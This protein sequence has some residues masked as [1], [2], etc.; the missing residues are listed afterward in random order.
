LNDKATVTKGVCLITGVGPGTGTALVEA[1]V[2]GGYAVAMLARTEE[3]LEALSSKFEHAHAF[4]CDVLDTAKLTAT[5]A[6]IRTTLGAP[7]IVIHN[8]VGGAFGDFMEIDPETLD[9]NFQI[10]T[11]ALLHLSRLVADDMIEAGQG[12]ILATGNTSA[13]RGKAGFAG[14]APSKAAQRILLESIARAVGPKGIHAVYVAIDAVIDL[15][16]TREHFGER[17][18]DFYCKPADIAETCYSVAHQPRSAWVSDIVI[19]P[20]G[21]NW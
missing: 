10:N 8:A 16:W 20:F 7:T 6:H 19:R 9:R 2:N 15:A 11:M 1:F 12:V 14:F 18:D 4:P 3:R 13:Y 17:P 21:E 5:V